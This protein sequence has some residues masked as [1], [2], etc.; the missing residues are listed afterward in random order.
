M[1]ALPA[2]TSAGISLSRPSTRTPNVLRAPLYRSTEPLR[3]CTRRTGSGMLQCSCT[4]A[5]KQE[6]QLS[7]AVAHRH[8]R[9]RLLRAHRLNL[10]GCSLAASAIVRGSSRAMQ[11]E[12][13]TPC[14][15]SMLSI[16]GGQQQ[17]R[18]KCARILAELR[19]RSDWGV[20]AREV[21]GFANGRLF[22]L[23]AVDDRCDHPT[24]VR[25]A[26]AGVG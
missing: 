3:A 5:S 20:S 13:G 12:V 15:R 21:R 2:R 10:S 4:G 17:I 22:C 26:R 14:K 9:A 25:A 7:R 23:I 19:L 16:A 6:E 1:L 24:P 8:N 18:T 11:A